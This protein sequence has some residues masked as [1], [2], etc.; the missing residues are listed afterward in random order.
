MAT[1][2]TIEAMVITI[3][4]SRMVGG[5]ERTTAL[6]EAAPTAQPSIRQSNHCK[7]N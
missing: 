6:R 2:N 3:V 5:I 1:G 4:G 7:L